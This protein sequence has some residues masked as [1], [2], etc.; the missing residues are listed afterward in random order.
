LTDNRSFTKLTFASK[1]TVPDDLLITF[2][3]ILSAPYYYIYLAVENLSGKEKAP[4]FPGRLKVF[5]F[6]VDYT[7]DKFETAIFDI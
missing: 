2:A 5:N 4:R 6:F 7:N 3:G 1:V